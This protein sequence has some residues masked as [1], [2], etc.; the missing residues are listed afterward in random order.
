MKNISNFLTTNIGSN[1][2]ITFGPLHLFILFIA[3]V[4]SIFIYMIKNESKKFELF[5]GIT[6]I[7][8]QLFLYSWYFIGKFKTFTEGLPLYH[9]R[10]AIIFIAIG[11]VF[12][13]NTFM[14]IGSYWGIFGSI[15]ALLFP[16]LDPFSFPHITQFSYFIGHLFLLWGSV[17]ILAV[18]NICMSKSDFKNILIFTNI[19]HL[20]MFIINNIIGSNYGYMNFPPININVHLNHILYSLLVMMI[21]NIVLFIEYILINKIKCIKK[22]KNH[23]VLQEAL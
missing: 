14:K 4:A 9:C 20:S 19:Y 12:N 5:I 22:N 16:G 23:S 7:I 11:L 18:K 10:I 3:L 2:F 6:L 15:S 13:K 21:F 8:Q 17:Y 1:N